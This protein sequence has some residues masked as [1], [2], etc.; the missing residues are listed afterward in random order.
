VFTEHTGI[1]KYFRS[2]IH[3]ICVKYTL[4]NSPGI[5][6]VSNSLREELLRFTDRKIFVIPNVV[7]I[8]TIKLAEPVKSDLINIGFLGGLG[9]ANKG[10]DLLLNAVKLLNNKNI[11]LH[12]GGKGILLESYIRMAKDNGIYEQCR[13]YGGIMPEK[14]SDFYSQLNFFVLASRY[15]TFG[16]VLIE[17]MAAGLPVIATR[18][19]GPGEI[20]TPVAGML[21]ARDN[22]GELSDAIK[23]MS[24]TFKNYNRIEI[25]NYAEGRFGQKAFLE[26]ISMAY[27]E[28]MHGN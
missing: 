10:L 19:G 25:R 18:C 14:I 1:T 2:F 15:E 23:L 5:I 13:F 8:K 16:I 21:V 4:K 26:N 7:D 22:A 11:R 27:N 12:I 28:I 24:Q 6:C 20:V 3:K 9:N 17:A